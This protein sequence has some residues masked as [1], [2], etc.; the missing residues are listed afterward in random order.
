MMEL[1]Q[2]CRCDYSGSFFLK[3]EHS[4]GVGNRCK[5]LLW[6]EVYFI[7]V[8]RKTNYINQLQQESLLHSLTDKECFAFVAQKRG[9]LLSSEF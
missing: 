8:E 6:L 3:I 9:L 1:I 5:R 4:V 7:R 2:V